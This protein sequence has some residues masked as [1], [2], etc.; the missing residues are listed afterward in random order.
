MKLLP[1]LVALSCLFCSLSSCDF[2]NPQEDVPGFLLV[3]P[4]QLTTTPAQGSNSAKI[5]EVWVSVDGEFLGAFALPARVP[6]LGS[7][8]R[9]VSLQTGIKDNGISTTPD[10]YPFY[11]IT[12]TDIDIQPNQT[13]S[14]QPTVTYLPETRFAFIENF[15]GPQHIFT[16][17]RF[18]GPDQAM[19]KSTQNPFEGN[20]SGL[21][22]LDSANTIAEI[23]TGPVFRNLNERSPFVYLE[24]DY[25]S[26][27]PVLVGLVGF[28]PNTP[29]TGRTLYEAGFLPKENWNK[30]YFNLSQSIFASGLSDFQVV[31][32]AAIPVQ[33]GT[34]TRNSARVWLDNVKLLHF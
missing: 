5:T 23:A 27:V 18:G 19:Q 34:P 28:G 31:V 9:Q 24:M 10:I 7:G 17:R 25:K 15:E 33:N 32:Q 22:T 13:S 6:I 11:T 3:S 4:F 20:A 12:N 2:I 16:E 14:L 30:I 29:P 26:D 8:L 21:I 1:A